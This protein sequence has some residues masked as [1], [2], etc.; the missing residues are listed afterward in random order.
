MKKSVTYSPENTVR[1]KDFLFLIGFLESFS[2]KYSNENMCPSFLTVS[3]TIRTTFN[4]IQ[5]KLKCLV[6]WN[7]R[8]RF[9]QVEHLTPVPT[10]ILWSPRREARGEPVWNDPVSKRFRTF[11]HWEKNWTVHTDATDW[12]CTFSSGS[13]CCR[14]QPT[15]A[16]PASWYATVF[17]SVGCR[18]WVFFSRPENTQHDWWCQNKR[19]YDTSNYMK[20]RDTLS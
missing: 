11:S 14:N 2:D 7:T 5:W 17:F 16:C 4:P 8:T 12:S 19:N 13:A 1:K 6:R 15:M 9:L 20:H 18:T 10:W 3:Q